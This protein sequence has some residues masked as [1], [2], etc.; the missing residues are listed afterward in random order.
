MEGRREGGSK[1]SQCLSS[2]LSDSQPISGLQEISHLNLLSVHLIRTLVP[3]WVEGSSNLLLCIIPHP[4]VQSCAKHQDPNSTTTVGRLMWAL[5]TCPHCA[6]SD[7]LTIPVHVVTSGEAALLL[8]C[9][10]GVMSHL[11][12]AGKHRDD[13]RLLLRS[14]RHSE[15]SR[16]PRHQCPLSSGGVSFPVL[17]ISQELRWILTRTPAPD[18]SPFQDTSTVLHGFEITKNKV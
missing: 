1:K 10:A 3:R 14:C 13:S 2:H 11:S 8:F 5:V 9:E 16:V 17:P 4:S 18:S 15:G 12:K 6:H 7:T